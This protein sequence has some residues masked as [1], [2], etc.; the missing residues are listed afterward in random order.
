[1]SRE[2]RVI[3]KAFDCPLNKIWWG[4]V[5]P[6]IP[7]Q[8]CDEDTEDCPVCEGARVVYPS[9]ELN[10]VEIT[11]SFGQAVVRGEYDSYG[12]QMWETISQGSPISPVCDSP[13]HLAQW[14]ADNDE[15]QSSYDTWLR[16]IGVGWAP[17][18]VYSFRDGFQTG[19]EAVAKRNKEKPI[20]N[21]TNE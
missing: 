9:V 3:A 8:Q 13:E 17:S 5:L 14:L 16:M 18:A 15:S 21:S 6:S 1:M 7:C 10:W 2:V 19:V 20:S 4:Y 12:F 11:S